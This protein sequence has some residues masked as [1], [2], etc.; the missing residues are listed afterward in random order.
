MGK[1]IFD[2]KLTAIDDPRNPKTLYAFPVDGEGIPKRK[3][4]LID[5]GKV[6]EDSICYDSY[7]AGKQKGK[8]STGHSLS[9]IFGYADRPMPF[10]VAVVAGDSSMEE[11]IR[12]T[13]HGIFITRFHYTNPTE[14]TK[15]V[16]TGLTRDGTFLIENGEITKPVMNLRYTDSMLSALGEIPMLGKK[17]ETVDTTTI[18][19]MKLARLRFTGTTQY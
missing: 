19:A 17:T 1:R 5:K 14:P 4:T 16:L 7:T 8:K 15:A 18:P 10:N 13:K 6:S 9:S 11:M 3:M 12:D 2:E